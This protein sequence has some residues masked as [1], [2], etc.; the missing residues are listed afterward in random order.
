MS[1]RKTRATDALWP[2][3]TF[4]Y[5]PVKGT[6]ERQTVAHSI[7]IAR[8]LAAL[9]PASDAAER[10]HQGI[11]ARMVV[12]TVEIAGLALD[13]PSLDAPPEAWAAAYAQFNRMDGWLLDAWYGAL[14]AVDAP[15]NAREFW[16]SHKLTE[17]ERKNRRSVG[18]PGK[19]TSD[20][21]SPSTTPAD[22]PAP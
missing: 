1:E 16:P 14:N 10:S 4:E 15:P 21:G 12:Q 17:D 2:T 5:G 9:P 6:V 22:L 20:A 13:W 19:T 11:F 7:Q 18:S 3:L 8:V